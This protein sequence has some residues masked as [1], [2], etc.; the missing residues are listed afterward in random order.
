M[1][2]WLFIA[3]QLA[4][5]NG[6]EQIRPVGGSLWDYIESN[7]ISQG[8]E[9]YNPEGL[10]ENKRSSTPNADGSKHQQCR[11]HVL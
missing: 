4:L 1:F 9:N 2:G 3:S 8:L 11:S 5:A 6:D 10:H 7:A